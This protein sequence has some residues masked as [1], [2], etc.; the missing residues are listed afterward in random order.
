MLA[1]LFN[2]F[3]TKEK[4]TTSVSPRHSRES[5]CSAGAMLPVPTRAFTIPARSTG[6]RPA[7][8]ANAVDLFF[9]VTARRDAIGTTD[10][11]HDERL[12]A[13]SAS[14]LSKELPPAYVYPV[15][16]TVNEFGEE[17][18]PT[19]AQSASADLE[20]GAG[21]EREPV[22]LAQYLFK[23]GFCMSPLLYRVKI[24][25]LT[26]LSSVSALVV[27]ELHHLALAIIRT[28]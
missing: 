24:S 16:T 8:E 15:G 2:T 12:V 14:S 7:S 4:T 17:E 11:R 1:S 20:R 6:A 13:S 25:I 21:D 10:S 19:Y 22:T 26:S 28:C 27:L 23:F 3:A 18:L 5:F 9:G